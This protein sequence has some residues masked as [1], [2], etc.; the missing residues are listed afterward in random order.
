M[1]WSTYLGGNG[2]D[3]LYGLALDSNR[4][5][6]ASG[7]SCSSN[8]PLKAQIQNWVATT[9]D[10]PC[11]LFVTTLSGSLSS[12][13][14]YSTYLG[15]GTF[16]NQENI[17]AVDKKFNV[18]VAGYDTGNIKATKGALSSGTAT[19]GADF[20]VFVSKLDIVADLALALSA[21]PSPVPSGANLTYTI[22]V[23]NK[24]PDFATN[25]LVTD[26]VPPARH[27]SVWIPREPLAVSPR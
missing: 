24:G 23:T 1:V 19:P 17:V 16:T 20:D 13:L 9:S 6:Y 10:R 15:A 8:F 11:Q 22:T 27:L 7:D 21:S 18:Y 3:Y 2:E 12:I 25:V 4:T 14:Y 26:S 5:V